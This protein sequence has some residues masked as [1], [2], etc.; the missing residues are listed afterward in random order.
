M[1]LQSVSKITHKELMEG[2]LT[3]AEVTVGDEKKLLPVEQDTAVVRGTIESYET[4][5]TKFGEYV[6]FD[7]KFEAIRLCDGE[8]FFSKQLIL[9]GNASDLLFETFAEARQEDASADLSFV[10]V[11]GVKPNFTA[12]VGYKHTVK[13]SSDTLTKVDPLAAIREGTDAQLREILGDEKFAAIQAGKPVLAL[14][15]GTTADANT[16]EVVEA[17]GGGKGK[18]KAEEPADA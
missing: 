5:E 18:A 8:K 4:G 14:A 11:L 10:M 17:K 2:K 16:G 9:P 13:L 3:R 1:A 7:G 12:A 15:D 6:R